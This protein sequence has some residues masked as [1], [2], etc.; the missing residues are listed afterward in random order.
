MKTITLIKNSFAACAALVLLSLTSCKKSSANEADNG[1][2]CNTQTV[3]QTVTS[4]PGVLVYVP[5]Q[6][7]WEVF[8]D[9]PGSIS[10]GCSFCDKTAIASL[11]AGQPTTATI[12]VTVSG[13]IKRRYE[14]QIPLS[15]THGYKEVYLISAV[16]IN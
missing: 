15:V 3:L 16:T 5:A 14:N 6:A 1:Y 11:V 13:S 7:E 8:L 9:L 2:G 4:T 12:N 10:I